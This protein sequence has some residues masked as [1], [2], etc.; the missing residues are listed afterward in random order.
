LIKFFI[1]TKKVTIKTLIG[2][3]IFNDDEQVF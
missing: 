2:D 3:I 1:F